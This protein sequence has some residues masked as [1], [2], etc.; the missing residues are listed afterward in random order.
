MRTPRRVFIA[1]GLLLPS[2]LLGREPA[3]A[4][5]AHFFLSI[6]EIEEHLRDQPFEILDWRGSRRED[7]RTQQVLLGFE[8]QSVLRVK[9]AN[10][11]P[12]GSRFNNE[13]RYEA[14]AYEIQ[15]L[16]LDE[17]EYVVPPTIIRAFP[18]D[19]VDDQI[20]DSRRTFGEAESVVVALQY[21][22]ANVRPD[23]FWDRRRAR[24]DTVYARHIGNMNILTYLIR[25]NDSNIGNFLISTFPDSPR[26]FS[27]DNG[28]AFRAPESDRGYEWREIVVDR[29]PARTIERL[30]AVTK[31][32]LENALAILVEFEVQDG[33]LVAVQPGENLSRRR[34]VRRSDGRIQF[35]L[36]SGEIDDIDRRRRDLV[37]R[38]ERGQ[39]RTF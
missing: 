37:R 24:E 13:P 28:V 27:V 8:D 1:V 12:G 22:L 4:Q 34:G 21:W 14:A 20:P 32:D 30:A 33:Q 10:A 38:A 19:Y 6:P 16:F 11:A 3:A 18:L 36:T 5:D 9:W 17:D 15:K 29:L 26:V 23:N 7:D 31:D 2:L 25:H 35:G 39:I